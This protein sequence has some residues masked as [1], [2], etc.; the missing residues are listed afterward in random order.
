AVGDQ[1]IRERKWQDE[2]AMPRAFVIVGKPGAVVTDHDR[3]FLKFDEALRGCSRDRRSR[4]ILSVA[5]R[6]MA[7]IIDPGYSEH[8]IKRILGEDVLDVGEQK[9]L[10]LLFMIQAERQDRF[11]LVEQRVIRSFE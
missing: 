7:G 9:F 11:D 5:I 2:G 4:P 10:V 3:R 8:W 1:S 6:F